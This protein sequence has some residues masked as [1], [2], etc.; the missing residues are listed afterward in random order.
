MSKDGR[1]SLRFDAK[2]ITKVKGYAKRNHT[3]VTSLVERHLRELLLQEK[4]LETVVE[5]GDAEQV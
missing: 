2:L 5:T 1:L 3:T 4:Q